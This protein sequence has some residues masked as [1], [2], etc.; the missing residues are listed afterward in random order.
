MVIIVNMVCG[1]WK[2][3]IYVFIQE[4][5]IFVN[6]CYK[7]DRKNIIILLIIITFIG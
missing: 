3:E 5:K 1:L 2:N 6:K 7:I 4:N